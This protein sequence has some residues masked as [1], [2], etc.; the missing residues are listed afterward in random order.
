M[1]LPTPAEIEQAVRRGCRGLPEAVVRLNVA[2]A[3]REL[4]RMVEDESQDKR[5]RS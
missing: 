5:N 4:E 1:D 3:L 2:E